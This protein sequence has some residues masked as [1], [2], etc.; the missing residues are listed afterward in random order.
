MITNVPIII[1]A[2]DADPTATPEEKARIKAAL[3]PASVKP[4]LLTRKQVAELLGVHVETV[5]R[6]TRNGLLNPVNFTA[7]ALRYPEAEVFDFMQNGAK[8]E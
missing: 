5:K 6:Y 4:R 2:L 1:A 3:L 7:R 8:H